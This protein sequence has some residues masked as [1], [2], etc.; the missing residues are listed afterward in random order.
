M[1]FQEALEFVQATLDSKTAKQ[2]TASEKEILKAAWNKETYSNLADSLYLSAGYVKDLASLLWMRLSNIFGEKITKNNF[3]RVMEVLCG[4]PQ[5]SEET[6][7]ENNTDEIQDPKPSI[8]IV[9]DLVE[10]LGLLT[11]LLEK[12]GYIVRCVRNG[13]MALKTINQ[14]HPDL[15]LLDILM[16]EI[17]G[18]QVCQVLKADQ[19]TSGIP[20]IFLSAFDQVSNRLKAFE[21]GG[22]DYITKPFYPEEVVARVQTQLTIQQQKKELKRQIE[23]HQ[24]LAEIFYQSR[25]LLANLLNVSKDGIIA[26][27]AVRDVLTEK[28]NDFQCLVINP[29]FLKF[30]DQK[31]EDL[32]GKIVPQNLLN[33]LTPNMFDYLI[34]LVERGEEIEGKFCWENDP[35]QGCYYLTAIK[36]EDGCLITVRLINN[37]EPVQLECNLPANNKTISA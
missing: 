17:N 33:Q 2:L 28:I 25:S 35:D 29:I 36:F 24:Q 5:N 7:E 30:W 21:M 18:Y 31:R 4:T 32:T 10:N 27:Q 37:F 9:D 34:N 12:F 13:K 26:L 11:K 3:R 1:D 19:V 20:I 15:I 23:Y 14:I 8:L 22:V 16:P 6:I